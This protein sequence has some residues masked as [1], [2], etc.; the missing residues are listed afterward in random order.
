MSTV[1]HDVESAGSV[2]KAFKPARLLG[3]PRPDAV[4]STSDRGWRR[5]VAFCLQARGPEP[6]YLFANIILVILVRQPVSL[7]SAIPRASIVVFCG[8]RSKSSF[9]RASVV[10]QITFS[11][12]SLSYN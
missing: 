10:T 6:R 2:L 4:E 11:C 9:Q 7:R 12:K 5:K 8:T 1:C 3:A